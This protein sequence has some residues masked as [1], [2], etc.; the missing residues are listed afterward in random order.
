MLF[1]DETILMHYGMPKRSGRY[2]WGSG[3]NPYQH[4]RDFLGRV[5]ELRKQGV[6][7][8]D[9]KGK[10]YTGDTAI[11]KSLGLTTTQFRT[12]IAIANNNRQIYNQARI[13]SLMEDGLGP[14]EIG[15]QMGMSESTV[16]SIIKSNSE[17][18]LKEA[19]NTANFIKEQ[20]DKNGIVD[21]GGNVCRELN[22]SQEKMRQALYLLEREGY[23]VYGAG[24]AQITNPGQQINT[25]YICKPGTK[26]A[27]VYN[28]ENVH[29]LNEDNY[30]YRPDEDSFETYRY[31]KSMDSKRLMVRYS[32]EGGLEKDGIVEIRRG[33]ED[34]S[35]GESHYAQ[36]RILV[37][38]TKYVKGMAVYSDDMPDGVDVVFNTNKPA[39]TPK[40]DVLK[41]IKKDDPQNPFGSLIKAG[42]QSDYIDKDGN[43][44]M[45]LINKTRESGDWSDWKDA[46]PS[47]FL[48]K[49][50]YSLAKK[51]LDLAKADKYDEF[52]NI[53]SINNP[54]IKKH[55]LQKFSD[56]CDSAAVH[57]Q[58]AALPRQKYHVIIPINSLKDNEVYAPQY[59]DGSKVALIRYPHAG[60]FEIP[61]L[62]VNNR[63]A[64]AKKLIGTDSID[65]V[66]IN[67]NN[68]DRLSGAD[69]DG[70]TV[71]V[72]PTHDK[73]GKVKIV[74][75]DKLKDLEG[76]DPKMEY[77]ER[78]GMK[79]MNK[80]SVQKEMGVI[81]NLI[82]DMTL[83][84]ANEDELARAVKHSMVVIDAYK[85]KL[86]YKRSE[87]ENNISALK[88]AYQIQE[89]GHGGGAATI[90]SR[91]KG[92]TSVD[93]RQGTPHINIKGSEDYD[94]TRPEGAY[95]YKT[96]DPKNLYKP[97]YSVNKKTG[98]YTYTTSTGEKVKY[99]PTDPESRERYKPIKKIDKKTGEVTYSN[100]AGDITYALE[101]RTQKSTKMAET[102]DAY[103]LVSSAKHPM[104]L[105]YADY[106][107]SMKSLGNK[108]RM[109]MVATGNLKT[110]KA[111]KETYKKEVSS[112]NKK[113]NEAL[114]NSPRERAA[115]RMATIEVNK[116][117]EANPDMTN[118]DLKK[119]KQRALVS[120]R[121]A[122][123]AIS[124]K[125]RNIEITDSEWDAIQAGAISENTLKHI[126]DNAD[127]DSL[128]ARATPRATNMLSDAQINRIKAY[129]ASNYTIAEIA[130]KMGKSPSTIA[131][132]MKGA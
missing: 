107:N 108:A 12:E 71:M 23:P 127:V 94:P 55:F 53:M 123:G 86:D 128:R 36:V 8:T 27:E 70:D 45:S 76:F 116:M 15:R 39:G 52:E 24:T 103:S 93:K 17:G 129:S 69:F 111:A 63:H 110:N 79:Y 2:P 99:D 87:Y 91:A 31:P 78:P 83:L 50:S 22:I 30:V 101:K 80:K 124:R 6:T 43:K 131:K 67:K 51:Q 89:D 3:E 117:K 112:L 37:D 9:E 28:L 48:A 33:V 105:L 84:G 98:I 109:E 60:T 66:C 41:D 57:L 90:L 42:G 38:D 65:A 29:A 62:T 82:T 73:G 11:A 114:L 61:I 122:V 125:K 77:P 25:K 97:V 46:L 13:K 106:A 95:I 49:Q 130:E 96:A 21:V 92:Q 85:H 68:A 16:R 54:T 56:E 40:M 18:R 1:T 132:Y 121:N 14:T 32:E 88:K 75:T 26:H 81:S 34:L 64:P 119:A 102:D 19:M 72:I 118:E 44:Q 35:L 113:L 47:Q 7:Y 115:Q 4:S 5:E 10:T 126:L 120:S 20:V 59:P 58:A 104:E 74:S 100:K